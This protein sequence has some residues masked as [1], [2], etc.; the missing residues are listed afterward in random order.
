MIFYGSFFLLEFCM[1]MGRWNGKSREEF[2]SGFKIL[3][4]RKVAGYIIFGGPMS[5]AQKSSV[6]ENVFL[7]EMC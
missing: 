2:D 4:G 5:C 7:V 3:C 1:I 6:R